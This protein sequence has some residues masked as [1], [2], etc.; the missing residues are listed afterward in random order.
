MFEVKT[1]AGID[2]VPVLHYTVSTSMVVKF[3]QD[4]LGFP[5]DCD[6]RL[7]DNRAEWEKPTHPE[8]TY[9]LMRAIFK[10]E[11]I[12]I[13][14]DANDFISRHLRSTGAGAQFKEDV[15]TTLSPFM[16][17]K[18]LAQMLQQFPEEQLRLQQQGLY[19]R[20]LEDLCARP[21][22]FYDTVNNM[23]GVYL[24]PESII[25]KMLNFNPDTNKP[26]GML[27]FGA[28]SKSSNASSL[29][30]GV[31]LYVG[32]AGAAMGANGRVTVEDVFSGVRSLG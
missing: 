29:N 6:F 31:N 7:C 32:T 21:I 10:P 2:P 11:D 18:N 20:A 19:G 12:T 14:S 15:M 23:W 27:K 4:E 25:E 28:V 8:K 3:L 17:H 26:N 13:N 22:P 16:Y 24:A 1:L 9:V 5:F 30:W